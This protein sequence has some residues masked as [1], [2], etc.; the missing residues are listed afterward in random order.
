MSIRACGALI[1]CAV[2]LGALLTAQTL[3]LGPEFAVNTDT[4]YNQA[5]PSVAID[6]AGDFVV[7]W[8]TRD[9]GYPAG[10]TRGIF[11]QRFDS[12]GNK[13]GSEF[14]VN[15]GTTGLWSQ[16]AVAMNVTGDFVVIWTTGIG[17][18][19][20]GILGRRFDS[21]GVPLGDEFPVNTTTPGP[22]ENPEVA[23]D[24]SGNFVVVWK[25]DSVISGQRYDNNGVPQ[26][27]QFQIS[28]STAGFASYP[29]VAMSTTGSFVVVWSRAYGTDSGLFGRRYDGSGN[30][31]GGEFE[32][33]STES[34]ISPE[35]VVPDIAL[36]GAGN[37]VVAW[38]QWI[39]GGGGFAGMT[40][41]AR[42]FD[43]AGLP[44][45]EKFV[46]NAY[47]TG[48]EFRPS[49]GVDAT[50][51]FVVTWQKTAGLESG[52]FGQRVTASGR[53][54]ASE[55]QVDTHTTSH[56]ASPSVAVNAS[57]RVAVA[58]S[59]DLQ[60][61]SGLG[62]FARRGDV[63]AAQ[64][65]RVDA[66]GTGASSNLN[67]VLEPGEAIQVEPA[68]RNTLTQPGILSGA[69]SGL[70]G[71]AGPT[72]SIDDGFA[73]Y[74]TVQ[75][76]AESD[77]HTATQNCYGMTVSGA[78][79]V[80]HWDASFSEATADGLTKTWTLHVGGSF[81]DAPTSNPFYGFIESIFHNG[82]TAGCGGTEYCPGTS[83]LRKQMAV[84]VLKAK[85]G[86]DFVP[87]P[88]VGVFTDVPASDPYA[89]WI[90][91]L[92]HRGVVG[93]CGAGPTYCPE[94]PVL[95]Q[96]MAVFLL[97]ALEGSAYAPPLCAG[98]FGD[99]PCPGLFTDWIEELYS[100]QITGGCNAAP[101]L[102]CPNADVT[103]GQMAPFLAKTFGLLL[104]GP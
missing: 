33:T 90:E 36:D 40:I 38:Y 1:A 96:Q 53:R 77:C 22:Q 86:A 100:R 66:H 47:T 78:R 84:F 92:F 64:P 80:P 65:M 9:F 73:D 42:G 99:A 13:Q 25:D 74:G 59:S 6:P 4:A 30:P 5:F 75:P 23:S 48:G 12:A 29:S 58:W 63:Q 32:V 102:Y 68:W 35:R 52:I 27:S 61:G 16:P 28:I 91:E 72:Y 11:G 50:G 79:P 37:F 18:S 94:D 87:P 46:V 14:Q 70:T 56:Q 21:A 20:D 45:G 17:L 88:A 31:Q 62:V 93:G 103:R 60:D 69:A 34:D 19:P 55:F 41:L 85:E 95:R 81:D 24:G 2:G 7:V 101:L 3:P 26:G 10:M 8:G 43:S 51:D 104:Y 67:G 76:G 98:I 15:S 49:I 39:E 83:T 71:P 44:L 89:P 97:K 54:I 57:G 82:V